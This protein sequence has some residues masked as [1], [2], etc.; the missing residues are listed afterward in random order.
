MSTLKVE[1][2][3][4]FHISVAQQKIIHLSM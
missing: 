2:I 3:Q 4:L 1:Q